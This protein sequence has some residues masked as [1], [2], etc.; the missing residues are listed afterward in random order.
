MSSEQNTIAL[1]QYALGWGKGDPS[2]VCSVLDQS[3]T[4]TMTGMDQPVKLDN[5]VQFF[6]PTEDSD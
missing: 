4:F 3:Y 2:L 6:T 1:D 5:F